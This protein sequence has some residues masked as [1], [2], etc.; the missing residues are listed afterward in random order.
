MIMS[1]LLSTQNT[2]KVEKLVRRAATE[3]F[4]RGKAK[5]HYEHGHWWVVLDDPEG[6]E[7]FY[8]VVDSYPSVADTGLS[9]ERP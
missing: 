3:R 4:G 7:I 6:D 5:P 1:E 8:D 9:F 2:R